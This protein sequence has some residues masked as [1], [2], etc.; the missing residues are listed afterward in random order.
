MGCLDSL[1]G[2]GNHMGADMEYDVGSGESSDVSELGMGN[3]GRILN[4]SRAHWVHWAKMWLSGWY[5]VSCYLPLHSPI[6]T[7]LVL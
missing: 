6:P 2:R 5:L 1:L 3:M 7:S 4:N